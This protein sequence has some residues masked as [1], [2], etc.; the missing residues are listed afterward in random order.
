MKNP[1]DFDVDEVAICL[2]A[3]GLESKIDVFRE[4]AIDGAMMV[5]YVLCSGSH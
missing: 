3:I 1:K 2:M 5:S 4:N